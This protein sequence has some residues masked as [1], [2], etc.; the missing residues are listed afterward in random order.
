[1]VAYDCSVD[2]ADVFTLAQGHTRARFIALGA[3]LHTLEVPDRGGRVRNVTLGF[4]SLDKYRS[5]RVFFG[6]TIGRFANR[7]ARGAFSLDGVTYQLP[8]NNPP[9]S[10]HGGTFGFDT[11]PWNVR[12]TTE[13]SITFARL[14][15]DGEE[16]YPGNLSVDVSY[17]LH[18]DSLRIDYSASTD[19]ATPINLTN[20]AYFNLAG[21]DAPTDIT[22]H[23]LWLNA[24]HYT[25]VDASLIPTGTLEPVESTPFDFRQPTPIGE[26]IDAVH[27]QLE[28]GGGYDHNWVLDD[29]DPANREPILQARVVEP[30]SGRVLEVW[31]TEPGLQFYSGNLLDGS[32]DGTGGRAYARRAGFTLETQHFPDSPNRGN[33][34]SCVLRPGHQYRS[35]TIYRFLTADE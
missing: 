24:S 2:A 28:A 19:A 11:W 22:G 33:F 25:P 10:L 32:F 34:P 3:A 8:I 17:S 18:G 31:T 16:G 6:A 4:G 26:R 12:E 30:D 14:S 21:E 20:H 27:P 9:N 7:I 5:R 29:W 35:T 13:S 15:P 23:V 1:M